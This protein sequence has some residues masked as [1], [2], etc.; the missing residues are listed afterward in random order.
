MTPDT[1]RPSDDDDADDGGA[2]VAERFVGRTGVDEITL[3]VV[4][5][6]R[7][8]LSIVASRLR[9]RLDSLEVITAKHATEALE[10]LDQKDVDCVI[11]DYKMP[12]MNGLEFLEKCRAAEPDIPFILFTSKGSEDVAMD[13][14]NAGVTDYLQKNLGDEGFALLANR[15]EN[16]VEQYRT[17]KLARDAQQHVQRIHDHVTDAYLGLDAE[18]RVTYLDEFGARLLGGTREEFLGEELWTAVPAAADSPLQSAF[19]RAV[20]NEE[21][22]TFRMS[23][24]RLG[25]HFEVHAVPSADGLSAYFRDVTDRIDQERTLDEVADLAVSLRETTDALG[26]ATDRASEA[27]DCEETHAIAGEYNDLEDL[28]SDLELLIAGD[29]E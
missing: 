6:E 4:D 3:L 12:G 28:V 27:C 16:A 26:E 23:H 25:T 17:R 18:W 11:S 7:N 19:E 29:E 2:F 13:A 9:E 10:L 20:E 14:I 1:G 22:V 5:D 15:I 8:L 24:D 21:T